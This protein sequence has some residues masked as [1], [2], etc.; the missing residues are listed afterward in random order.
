MIT[1]R[2]ERPTDFAAREQ[3]L[4]RSF[5][6]SRAEKTSERLREDRLPAEGL[7]F[8]A[9]ERGRVVG[10][11]RLWHISAGPGCPALLLGPLA[12]SLQRRNQGIGTA[13]VRRALESAGRLGHRAVMLVGDAPYYS[14]FGFTTS[15]TAK[16]WLPGPFEADRLLGLELTDGA[17]DGAH[18]LVAATGLAEPKPDLA[19]LAARFAEPDVMPRAA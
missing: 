2:Q 3:L 5:G 13:L 18:G 14:R 9:V 17:L 1:I 8:T 11:V 7:S 16:L 10:T 4:D 15:K 12:V 19:A 6:A